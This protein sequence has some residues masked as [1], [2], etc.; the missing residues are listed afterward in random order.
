MAIRIPIYTAVALLVLA[1]CARNEVSPPKNQ[2]NTASEAMERAAQANAHQF[3]AFE[4][5][6]ADRK[7]LQARDLAR[8][9]DDD[10][11][12]KAARLAEQVTADARLAEARA[13]LASAKTINEQA[14]ET[15]E[16]LRRETEA[17]SGGTP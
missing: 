16:A 5:A 8:S 15:L 13:R 17:A 9:D 4:M 1:G 6:T 7:L 10:D 14:K 3:A 12:R 11:R 2:L